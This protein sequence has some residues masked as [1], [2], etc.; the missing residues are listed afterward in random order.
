MTTIK[1]ISKIANRS[2]YNFNTKYDKKYYL[3][4]RWQPGL[5]IKKSKKIPG[6]M[7]TKLAPFLQLQRK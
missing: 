2:K 6:E 7:T 1:K 4:I 5:V 3:F